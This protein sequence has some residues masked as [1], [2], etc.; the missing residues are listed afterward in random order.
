MKLN[1]WNSCSPLRSAYWLIPLKNIKIFLEERPHVVFIESHLRSI[2]KTHFGWQRS[3]PCFRLLVKTLSR[4]GF[5]WATSFD[6]DMSPYLP[7]F[8]WYH[9]WPSQF[10]PDNLFKRLK[11]TWELDAGSWRPWTACLPTPTPPP[12]LRSA[13]APPGKGCTNRLS[14]LQ[15]R[16]QSTAVKGRLKSR[17]DRPV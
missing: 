16:N 14:L 13:T 2:L 6:D 5:F 7:I 17:S 11:L 10:S 3:P 9:F 15:Q 8:F 12:T 1:M 4:T